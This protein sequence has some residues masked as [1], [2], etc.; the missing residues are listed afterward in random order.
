MKIVATLSLLLCFSGAAQTQT[1]PV[2]DKEY[3]ISLLES[4]LRD[5]TAAAGKATEAQ[6]NFKPAPDKWSLA[7]VAEHLMLS[8]IQMYFEVLMAFNAPAHPELRAQTA[9]ND[10]KAID[11]ILEDGKHVANRMMV[12]LGYR[13]SK[14]SLLQALKDRRQMSID[15]A[16]AKSEE[17]LR[18]HMVYKDKANKTPIR[19]AYQDLLVFALHITRHMRQVDSIQSDPNYPRASSR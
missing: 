8:E 9:G 1:A 18:T 4:T 17:E 2:H 10:S 14:E 13:G 11:F 5:F 15:L 3:L 19:D 7:E 6:W 12:P 16:R